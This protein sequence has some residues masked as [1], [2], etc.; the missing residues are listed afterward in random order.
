VTRYQVPTYNGAFSN[1]PQTQDEISWSISRDDR[2][3]EIILTKTTRTYPVSGRGVERK[4]P[5][6]VVQQS[7]R[8]PNFQF[9]DLIKTML[10][11]LM[12]EIDSLEETE[13]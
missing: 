3:H 7:M 10:D 5:P 6:K 9:S 12:A 13:W 4:R 1:R 8:I 2:E 11:S